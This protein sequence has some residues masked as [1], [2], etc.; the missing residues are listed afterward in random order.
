M[1]VLG[2]WWRRLMQLKPLMIQ[3]GETTGESSSRRRGTQ[4]H[5][6]ILGDVAMAASLVD[7]CIIVNP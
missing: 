6:L 7:W 5:A 4:P 1:G 3:D 2:A